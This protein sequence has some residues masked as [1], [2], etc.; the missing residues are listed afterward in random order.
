[1]EL[2]LTAAF[3]NM[4]RCPHQPCQS[5]ACIAQ[6]HS[7]AQRSAAQHVC[8]EC[9]TATAQHNNGEAHQSLQLCSVNC[10]KQLQGG[11]QASSPCTRGCQCTGREG[12]LQPGEPILVAGNSSSQASCLTL[13]LLLYS[14]CFSTRHNC[15]SARSLEVGALQGLAAA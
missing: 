10:S 1:M 12:C 3:H 2:K 5:S 7:T 13:Q 6:E 15:N 8:A 11:A 9:N 14:I 4:F